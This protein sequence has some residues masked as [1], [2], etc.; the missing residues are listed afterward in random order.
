MSKSLVVII[1]HNTIGYTD[2]LYEMLKPYE[3]SD[4][5]VIVLDNGSDEGKTSKYTGVR[6]DEN[7]GYGGGLDLAM[8]LLLEN[9]EYDSVAVLNSD[10]I[11]HGYNCVSQLRKQLFSR[12]DLMIVSPCVIQP[13]ANQCFWKAMHCWNA[14]EV[15]FI[16][17]VDF[18]FV[19]MKREFVE[20]VKSFNSKYGWVQDMIAGFVCEDNNWK[21]GIC[22]WV[23]I[24]HLENGTVKSNPHLSDYNQKAQIEMDEYFKVRGLEARVAKLRKLYA[25]YKYES[26][27]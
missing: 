6:S 20:K 17:A 24:I 11:L 18:Q 15:R 16:P 7:T 10:L 14:T 23:P 4:Y 26:N 9:V 22:D 12:P 8:G 5:D 3:R 13:T 1:H 25:N 21:I 2:S 19:L 27:Q